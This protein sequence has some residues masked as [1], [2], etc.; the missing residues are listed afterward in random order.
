MF[1]V[2]IRQITRHDLRGDRAEPDDDCSRFVEPTQMGI[3]CG[4]KTVSDGRAGIFFY[5]EKQGRR[6]LVK[7]TPEKMGLADPALRRTR[8][9]T[10]AQAQRGLDM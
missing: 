2:A 1:G 7:P 9:L 10:R 5:R 6:S 4:E 3:A 8:A